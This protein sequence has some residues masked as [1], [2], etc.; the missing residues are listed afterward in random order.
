MYHLICDKNAKNALRRATGVANDQVQ[1][2]EK[3][4]TVLH[5]GKE[6]AKRWSKS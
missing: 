6:I 1:K 4:A 2:K 5:D 3:G